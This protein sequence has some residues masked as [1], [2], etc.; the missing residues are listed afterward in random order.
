M[1]R[2]IEKRK[3]R[4]KIF[5][6]ALL[7][8]IFAETGYIL[9]A[10]GLFSV[11]LP[12]VPG[13]SASFSDVLA[14][15]TAYVFFNGSVTRA[16]AQLYGDAYVYVVA[17]QPG[18]AMRDAVARQIVL[19]AGEKPVYILPIPLYNT[20]INPEDYRDALPTDAR[21]PVIL[22]TYPLNKLATVDAW[23]QQIQNKYGPLQ[24]K[25]IRIELSGG[26]PTSVR[27]F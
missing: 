7:A 14:V 2:A 24:S 9:G 10:T 1:P 23:L 21:N 8:L 12:G 15:S 18:V 13:A 4:G 25:Y 20:P 27:F 6:I 16:A 17:Y 5:L 3:K 22:L 11:I 26:Q 19:D